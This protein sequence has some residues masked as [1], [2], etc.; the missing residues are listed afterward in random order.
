[1]VYEKKKIDSVSSL[2][3]GSPPG[4]AVRSTKF[5]VSSVNFFFLEY[6]R[7]GRERY[8]EQQSLFNGTRR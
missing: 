8:Q 6:T 4:G 5:V 2:L 3:K 7:H 1:M